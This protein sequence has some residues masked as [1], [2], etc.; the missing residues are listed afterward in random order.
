MADCLS[1]LSGLPNFHHVWGLSPV[2]AS[3]AMAQTPKLRGTVTLVKGES[4]QCSGVAGVRALK[5]R[6]EM[7]PGALVFQPAAEPVLSTGADP[8]TLPVE[9]ALSLISVDRIMFRSVRWKWDRGENS[10]T[11][12]AV[13][14]TNG[15]KE[16]LAAE[17]FRLAFERPDGAVMNLYWSWLLAE[18]LIARTGR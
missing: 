7:L 14:Y 2:V 9:P 11:E 13:M 3:S 15:K 16:T 10:G 12:L 8:G 4:V 5:E 1:S 17:S 6:F 18:L